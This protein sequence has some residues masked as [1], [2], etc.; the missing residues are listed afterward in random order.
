MEKEINQTT[1]PMPITNDIEE[2]FRLCSQGINI[3]YHSKELYKLEKSEQTLLSEP[4]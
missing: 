2:Y 3:I 4:A 1:K